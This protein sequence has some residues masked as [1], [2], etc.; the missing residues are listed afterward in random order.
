MAS[1][2]VIE[3]D[4][5]TLMLVRSV[6]SKEGHEVATASDGVEGLALIQAVKP[7]LVVSDVHMPGLNGF[8]MLAQLRSQAEFTALPVILLTSLQERAHMRIGMTTGADD[9]ITKPFRPGELREAVL[10]QLRRREKQAEMQKLAAEAAVRVAVEERTHN[11]SRLYEQ[12]LAKALSERWPAPGQAAD[13]EHLSDATVLFVDIPVFPE[14]AQALTPDELTGLVKRFYGSA[15]D[16]VYLF[17][18]RSMQF[19][20]EGLLAIFAD[21][22]DTESVSHSLRAA[23]SALGLA[24]AAHAMTQ[25][26]QTL[27]S[28]RRA[29]PAFTVAMALH[30]G[31]VTLARLKDPLHDAVGQ[32][33]P[34]GETTVTAMQLQRQAQALGWPIAASISTVRHI[35]GAVRTGRRGLVRLPGRPAPFDAVELVALTR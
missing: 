4:A 30:H 27:G 29:L 18:A 26:L 16:T 15:G 32:L 12:R 2:V 35:A 14:L 10:A 33:L 24:S 11:L 5:G 17:G 21:T 28:G 9:Y 7:D 1:I 23:R 13:D 19:V 8:E 34:V 25:H 20:G 6:L 22:S 31:P 3:D